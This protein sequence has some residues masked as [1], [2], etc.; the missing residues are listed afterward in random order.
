MTSE[1][2]VEFIDHINQKRN[3]NRWINLRQCTNS[4]NQFNRPKASNNTSG[5]KGVSWMKA[6][7]K[8]YAVIIKKGTRKFLG[9][10]NTK[11]RA[12]N[13][14]NLAAT[15]MQGEFICLNKIL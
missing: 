15:E 12:A 3:D 13:A 4:E 1:W 6:R 5:F 14:Y 2:P 9:Y 10:F 8:W 11:E 7:K